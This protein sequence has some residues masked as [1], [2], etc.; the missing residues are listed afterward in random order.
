MA[1]RGL[2]LIALAAIPA[3]VLGACGNTV[4]TPTTALSASGR[5]AVPSVAVPQGMTV[6]RWFVGLGQGIQPN[7]IEAQKAFVKTYNASQNKIYINLEIIPNSSAYDVLKTEIAAGDAPDIIGP[8]GVRGRNGF[9][10]VFLDLS[11]EIKTF[12]YDTTKFP[13]AILDFLKQGSDGQIGLPYLI[14]P[15]FIF[16]NKD[17]FAQQ[18]LPD[19]PKKVGDQWNGKDWTWDTLSTIAAQ[20]TLDASGKK[21]TDAGF[22]ASK[23]AQFGI[24]FQWADARRVA[25]C[26]TAGSFVGADGKAAIPDGWKTA[27]NWYYNAMWKGHYAPT[28]KFIN[29]TLL[30]SGWT[31]SS[32]R[33]AMDVSWVWAISTFGALGKDGKSTAKFAN[34]DIAVMPSYN[35]TTSSPTDADTFTIMKTSEH[36]NE[37]FQAMAAIMADKNLQIVYGGMPAATSDQ[38]AWFDQFDTYLNQ[39]FPGNKVSWS[40]LQEMENYP[41]D[42][43]PEADVPNFTKVIQLA[44]A[45][46]TSLQGTAGLNVDNEIA[47]L[48]TD[49]QKAFDEAAASPSPTASQEP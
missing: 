34:W 33:V 9:G 43:S 13:S 12:G 17:I 5:T 32:G 21:S 28:S 42:P 22:D 11:P 16:Y 4:A 15:G 47:K 48:Q 30:N 2:R 3:L 24:D 1:R 8:V 37:A 29:S 20:L 39:I 7:Q 41:A 44:D 40:V 31:V 26:W 19:L 18:N 38:Q 36:P 35:G 45:F 25:S 23:T 6:V 27:W 46:Y 10:G 14:D 49:I